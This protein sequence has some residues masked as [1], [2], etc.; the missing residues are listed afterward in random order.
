MQSE[1]GPEQDMNLAMAVLQ[2]IGPWYS[3][4][5]K[6]LFFP[7]AEDND[8]IVSLPSF[9]AWYHSASS[10]Q[11]LAQDRLDTVQTAYQLICKTIEREASNIANADK[12]QLVAAY[13]RIDEIYQQFYTDMTESAR[14]IM[15]ERSGFDIL[16]GLGTEARLLSDLAK[17]QERLDRGGKPF[18]LALARLDQFEIIEKELGEDRLNDSLQIIAGLIKKSLRAFDDAYHLPQGQFVF[19]IKQ[20]DVSG[21]LSALERLRDL[22]TERNETVKLGGR[23]EP[24]TL[25]CSVAEPVPEEDP[26]ALLDELKEDLSAA[27]NISGAV[28]EFMETTALEKYISRH[29]H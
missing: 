24:L 11:L 5:L 21:G 15:M 29:Q 9:H 3:S 16:T 18:T 22:M 28:L 8:Q 14:Q 19:V 12:D 25:S 10:R 27:N 7:S 13:E 23:K 4:I 1:T 2:D 26:I 17:E 6:R 20:V